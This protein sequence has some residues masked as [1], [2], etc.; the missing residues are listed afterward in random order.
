LACPGGGLTGRCCRVRAFAVNAARALRFAR[1]EN[2][3]FS[4]LPPL[5]AVAYLEILGGDPDGSSAVVLLASY[6][7]SIVCIATY[8]HIVNDI[9]DVEADRRADKA[10]SMA[11]VSPA[12]RLL[13]ATTFL[14]AGFL[15]AP[16]AGYD[17]P[18]LLLLAF[19]YLL[20]TIYSIPI[21]RLK[22]KGL[23]GVVCDAMGAHVTPTLVAVALFGATAT[24]PAGR[25]AFAALATLWAG[26]LGLKG[27]LHH[28]IAD[29]END[30]RAG[31]VTFA[32]RSDH[33]RL[34]RFLTGFNLCVELP[35][36]AAFVAV[37]WHECP[38][39]VAAL[40]LYVASET[41]KYKLGFQFAL[42]AD[43]ATI[44]A[45]M[46]FTN[47]LFYVLWLPLAAAIQLG[48]DRSGWLALPFLHLAVFHPQAR[49]QL[50]DW[51]SIVDAVAVVYRSRR[52]PT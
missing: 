25:A 46:P 1:P 16:I 37:A 52:P 8:G 39:A 6:L 43:E 5:L 18:V 21:T 24:P 14:L 49:Q 29:R 51:R 34:Q 7:F 44:R 33:G 50:R 13:L 10:N 20:P 23:L 47:E 30:N 11:K 40:A 31:V 27:I 48:V 26:V 35:V 2:W 9:H 45:N 38:L 32:T 12:R 42:T 17:M 19:N 15:P 41:C 22:E 4:K 3:F 36:S 28:Q